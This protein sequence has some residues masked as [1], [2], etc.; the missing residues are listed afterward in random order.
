MNCPVSASSTPGKTPPPD[1]FSMHFSGSGIS[2]P[3]GST[4]TFRRFMAR[5][6]L[7]QRSGTGLP[8]PGCALPALPRSTV[9]GSFRW[10]T[11]ITSWQVQREV[12][13]D[14]RICTIVGLIRSSAYQAVLKRIGGYDISH[15]GVI[16]GL[17]DDCTLTEFL[18]AAPPAG[19][20]GTESPLLHADGRNKRPY[21]YPDQRSNI[22]LSSYICEPIP[23]GPS[24][25]PGDWRE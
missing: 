21:S 8:T 3:H 16:R 15:A 20:Q 11:R 17:A 23:S 25:S 7:Q 2:P 6:R 5:M 1:R 9:S 18:P 14:P 13:A 12:L 10:H 24:F 4:G 22:S 19:Y